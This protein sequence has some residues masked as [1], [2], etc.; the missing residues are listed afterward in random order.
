MK[1]FGFEYRVSE[2]HE[3]LHASIGEVS[4]FRTQ[5][6]STITHPQMINIPVTALKDPDRRENYKRKLDERAERMRSRYASKRDR[7]N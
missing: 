4:T 2:F 1:A 3:T 5:Q 7:I 6:P